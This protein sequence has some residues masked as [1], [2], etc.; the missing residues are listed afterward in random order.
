MGTLVTAVGLRGKAKKTFRA[1]A[2]TATVS[3][4]TLA[5]V[6]LSVSPASAATLDDVTMTVSNNATSATGATY[7]WNFTTKTAGTLTSL[8][9]TVPALTTLTTPAPTAYG[10]TSCTVGTPTLA[11]NTVTV[12]LTGC[13]SVAASTPVSLAI[14]GFTNTSAATTTAFASTASTVATTALDSGTATGGVNFNANTTT[15][16]VVVPES[17]SFTNANTAITLLPV[18]GNSTPAK[19]AVKLTVATNAQGG[20]SLA[21]CMT[22]GIT[23]GSHPILQLAPTGSLNGMTTAFGAQASVV[24]NNGS[25]TVGTGTTALQGAWDTYQTG[26]TYVGYAPDCILSTTNAKVVTNDGTTNGDD[27]TLTNAVSADA[28][29]PNGDYTGI[30]TYQLTPSY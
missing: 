21:S 1:A 20:Y 14:S 23:D 8:T 19:S 12:P 3:V 17:L 27:L 9:F 5:S 11:S 6:T 26:T 22:T 13:P 16:N 25:G 29:Q 10:L 24:P 2:A 15:V 18:P 4:L 30:I 7:T 28:V